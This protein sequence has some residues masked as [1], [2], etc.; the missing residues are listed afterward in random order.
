M[1]RFRAL[2]TCFLAKPYASVVNLERTR[3]RRFLDSSTWTSRSFTIRSRLTQ[4]ARQRNRSI[5]GGIRGILTGFR[6]RWEGVPRG[7]NVV[8]KF[9][10]NMQA[11]FRKPQG[12][13]PAT[14]P[15]QGDTLRGYPALC[16]GY[17]GAI[18]PAEGAVL[19]KNDQPIGQRG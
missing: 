12:S 5:V 11:R 15:N 18:L 3:V 2:R 13:S 6:I 7:P 19:K 17:P 8:D 9:K 4:A 10:E 1:C 14:E 16:Q